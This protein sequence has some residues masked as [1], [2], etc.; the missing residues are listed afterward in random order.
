MRYQTNLI[1]SCYR[2]VFFS[3]GDPQQ[4]D[5]DVCARVHLQP[6]VDQRMQVRPPA[7]RSHHRRGPTEDLRVQGGACQVGKVL[8]LLT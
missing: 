1:F 4:E 7:L 2:K 8:F 5:K 3:R 6:S